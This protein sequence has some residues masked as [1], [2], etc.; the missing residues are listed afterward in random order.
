[1]DETKT[2]QRRTFGWPVVLALFILV[3]V[4]AFT[5]FSTAVSPGM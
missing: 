2:V 5:L 1:M 4:I 3:L